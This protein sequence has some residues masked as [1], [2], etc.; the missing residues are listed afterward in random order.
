MSAALQ[1]AC[2][3]SNGQQESALP[4]VMGEGLKEDLCQLLSPASQHLLVSFPFSEDGL[5]AVFYQWTYEIAV[6]QCFTNQ[7]RF[8]HISSK[9]VE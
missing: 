6:L 7:W 4:E 1:R 9:E 5:F 8:M 3:L 2:E